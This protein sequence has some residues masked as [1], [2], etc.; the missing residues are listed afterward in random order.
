MRVVG[1]AGD[2][3]EAIDLA[4]ELSPDIVVMDITMPDLNGIEATRQILSECPDTKVVA[5]SVHSGKLNVSNRTCWSPE[6]I[7]FAL[8]KGRDRHVRRAGWNMDG[9][10]RLVD[11]RDAKRRFYN[12][13][14]HSNSFVVTICSILRIRRWRFSYLRLSCRTGRCLDLV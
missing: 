7:V 8:Q 3:R 5:L 4:W 1:E 14:P 2:G 9:F 12:R 10:R 11:R 13:S 6:M